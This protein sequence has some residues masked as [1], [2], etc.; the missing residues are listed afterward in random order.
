[1]IKAA[2]W[3]SL[4][5]LAAVSYG[6]TQEATPK[7]GAPTEQVVA[8]KKVSASKEA[9]I[10]ELLD[11]TGVRETVT[12]TM[13]GMEKSMRPL[14]TSSLPPGDY[15]EQLI[16]L[17]IKKFREKATPEK[18]VDLVIPTYDK[19]FTE[20]ELTT[21][22]SFYKTPVGSKAL[23]V[24]PKIVAEA[25]EKGQAMGRELGKQ[26]MEEVLTEHPELKKALEEAAQKNQPPQN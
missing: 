2:V 26:S 19:Y 8:P 4:I 24:L 16:D 11:L 6:I 12:V 9:K 15:R 5:V 1:M 25:Q 13:N 23:S 10:R 3:K 14:L 17:F 21:V 18:M 20:E 22:I 7:P